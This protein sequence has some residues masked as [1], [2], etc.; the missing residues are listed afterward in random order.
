MTEGKRKIAYILIFV[1]MLG[2]LFFDVFAMNVVQELAEK[3]LLSV[4]MC[5]IIFPVEKFQTFIDVIAVAIIICL[6]VTA[7]LITPKEDSE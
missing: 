7:V 5:G 1:S 3:G 6:G 4:E 2:I